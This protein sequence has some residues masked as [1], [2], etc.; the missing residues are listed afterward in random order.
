MY[1]RENFFE[2]FSLDTKAFVLDYSEEAQY[3]L[4]KN[5]ED[6]E[7]NKLKITDALIKKCANR[8]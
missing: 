4:Q 8:I 3:W 1:T 6:R 5:R 2:I 7:R